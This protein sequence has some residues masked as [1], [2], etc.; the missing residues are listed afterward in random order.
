MRRLPRSIS[1]LLALLCTAAFAPAA[2]AA[3]YGAESTSDFIN[4]NATPAVQA[5]ALDKLKAQG[6][7]VLRVNIG[8]NEIAIGF[9]VSFVVALVV[10]RAFVA[11]VSRSGFAPFAWY[12]IAA[13]ALAIFLLSR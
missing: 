10:I 3:L 2:N 1:F 7:N 8:W 4:S 11:F 9:A 13:G 5:K 12:R 6:G